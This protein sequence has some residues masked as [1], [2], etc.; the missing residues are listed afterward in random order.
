MDLLSFGTAPISL[1]DPVWL[2]EVTYRLL[3]QCHIMYLA[4][5]HCIS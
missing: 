1:S 4:N 5:E 2:F 3:F